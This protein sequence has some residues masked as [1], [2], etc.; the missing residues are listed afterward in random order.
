MNKVILIGNL[1]Q[2]GELKEHTNASACLHL[3]VA[4]TYA[5]KKNDA[6]ENETEWHNCVLWGDRALR[7]APMMTKGKHI[8]IEGHLRT[9]QFEDSHG[10]RRQLT[11]VVVEN[12]EFTGPKR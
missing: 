3:R 8:A 2:D 10:Q 7:V 1:G 11:E 6:W 5:V 4:T 9:A 12:F